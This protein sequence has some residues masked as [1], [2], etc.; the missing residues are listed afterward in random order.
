MYRIRMYMLTDKNVHAKN[1][2][3]VAGWPE[4]GA[5][6]WFYSSDTYPFVRLFVPNFIKKLCQKYFVILLITQK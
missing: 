1:V 4:F 5:P 6:A 2:H 3:S